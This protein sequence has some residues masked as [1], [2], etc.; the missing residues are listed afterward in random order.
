MNKITIPPGVYVYTDGEGEDERFHVAFPPERKNE[1][2]TWCEKNNIG[3]KLTEE[4]A[5]KY[6]NDVTKSDCH[7]YCDVSKVQDIFV[8]RFALAV[9]F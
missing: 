6:R 9:A 1:F 4:D 8:I 5:A 7:V 3:W 2:N